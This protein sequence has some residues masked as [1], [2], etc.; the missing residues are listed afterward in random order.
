[1]RSTRDRGYLL[2]SQRQRLQTVESLVLH[3][4]DATR[5]ASGSPIF[6]H[7]HNGFEG[8]A[9]NAGTIGF[10]KYRRTGTGRRG[11]IVVSRATNVTVLSST[12]ANGIEHF[13]SNRLLKS[14]K[15]FNVFNS[16]SSP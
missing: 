12:F 13:S 9:M 10:T 15:E 2:P 7:S 14:V 3:T 6:V 5:G 1:M 16:S 8:V 4:G 11:R